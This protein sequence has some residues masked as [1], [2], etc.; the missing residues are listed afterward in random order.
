[1]RTTRHK[2][3]KCTSMLACSTFY[4]LNLEINESLVSY[5]TKQG[6][7]SLAFPL[8]MCRKDMCFHHFLYTLQ[9]T[10]D[11]VPHQA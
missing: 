4:I 5:Y 8:I 6:T 3:G 2:R 9:A 10:D 7:C 11:I 1:M